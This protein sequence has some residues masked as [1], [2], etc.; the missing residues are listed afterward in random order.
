MA[1]T[2]TTEA[3]VSQVHVDDGSMTTHFPPPSR[4]IEIHGRPSA[5]AAGNFGHL[6]P[7]M[8]DILYRLDLNGHISWI[9]DPS[10]LM[11]CG[12]S[13]FIGK[14]F[15]TFI[16]RDDTDRMMNSFF[17]A[18]EAKIPSVRREQFRLV[19]V[20]KKVLWIEVTAFTTFDEKDNFICEEG[21]CR[22]ITEH[23]EIKKAL[24]RV[25]S[26]L[27]EKV[28]ARNKEL[29]VANKELQN[30]I[31]ERMETE[32]KLRQREAELES[33]KL[34]LQEANTTLRVLLQKRTED[35]RRLEVEILHNI[36]N[37]VLPYVQ[38][39]QSKPLTRSQQTYLGILS[40]N[41][42]EVATAFSRK[43]SLAYFDLSPSEIRVAHLIKKGVPTRRIAER[44][45]LSIRTVDAYRGSIRRK[46]RINNRSVNL[47][48]FLLAMSQ[49][50]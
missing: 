45:N 31:K 37:L 21:I 33:E 23:I 8:P 20:E 44:L 40:A 25:H 7:Q 3:S 14:H 28:L 32:R 4:T 18:V 19:T 36:K 41:L 5:A 2:R 29:L 30:E 1:K 35:R 15:K 39:I 22:D 34:N 48:T 46:L 17:A 9:K 16:H 50:G 38:K 49:Q 12:S 10:R 43:L 26:E 27:E 24:M 47:R 13:F 42:D 11:G 6:F